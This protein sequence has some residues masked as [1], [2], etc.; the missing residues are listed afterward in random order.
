[1]RNSGRAEVDDIGIALPLLVC[2]P[3]AAEV[4][5]AEPRTSQ[6]VIPEQQTLGKEYHKEG[7]LSTAPSRGPK[8]ESAI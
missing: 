7:Y 1:M 8:P 2:F 4:V 6:K 5:L 3:V